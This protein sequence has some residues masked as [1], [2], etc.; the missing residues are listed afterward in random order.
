MH[1]AQLNVA[2]LLEPLDAPETAEFVAALEP[3]NALADAAA[4]FVWRLQADGGD[5]TSIRILDDDLVIVNMSVWESLDAL[6]AFVYR[7][8]HK[9]V[10]RRKRAW[11]GPWGGPHLVLFWVPEGAPPTLDEALERLAQLTE[12][13]PT[14]EAFDFKRPFAADGTPIDLRRRGSGVADV[15]G[16]QTDIAESGVERDAAFDALS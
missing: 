10:L 6:R 13:G 5:A 15:P 1:L 2:R 9:L 8:D 11:F 4:G 12:E 16:T 3:V 7:S 14:A